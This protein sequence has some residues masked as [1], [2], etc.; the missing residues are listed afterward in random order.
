MSHLAPP[1]L[2]AA[3]QQA[4]LKAIAAN[5]RDHT[6]VSM[7]RGYRASPPL[8]PQERPGLVSCRIGG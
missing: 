5:P 3:E 2:T 4:I 6:I 1:T 8:D 7:A